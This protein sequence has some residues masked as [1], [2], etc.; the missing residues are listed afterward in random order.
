MSHADKL[1]KLTT[2]QKLA[3]DLLEVVESLW[4]PE[5]HDGKS[6]LCFNDKLLNIPPGDADVPDSGLPHKQFYMHRNI[7]ADLERATLTLKG[8]AEGKITS[9]SDSLG[10]I[11]Y[12]IKN[13]LSESRSSEE[14]EHKRA[15]T[16]AADKFN[17]ALEKAT[18]EGMFVSGQS[19]N[20]KSRDTGRT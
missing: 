6:E 10:D 3:K 18:L 8:I 5:V 2:G 12:D 7:P 4:S 16:T 15:I 11:L 20:E 19:L 1:S 17:T 9:G 14:F 13:A